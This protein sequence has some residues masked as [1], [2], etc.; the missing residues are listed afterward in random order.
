VR[1]E[2]KTA[3]FVASIGSISPGGRGDNLALRNQLF[4]R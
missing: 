1:S 3:S 4:T 2:R